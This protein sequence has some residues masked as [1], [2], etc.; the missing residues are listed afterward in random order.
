VVNLRRMR[1]D[2]ITEHFGALAVLRDAGLIQHLGLSD[3]TTAHLA[4]ALAIAPV[5][6]VQ[7]R[8]SL[9]VREHEG[10]L[11]A[12][13]EQGI[14]FVPF[15]AIAGERR[16][17]GGSGADTDQL[18]EVARWH[19]ATPAQVRLAWTLQQGPNVLAIPG[20]GNPG[21]LTENVAADALR[22]TEQDLAV[23]DSSA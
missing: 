4:E 13:R 20:T 12:C 9:K 10:V 22:L 18:L 21:H 6:C 1:Q 5:V 23:L 3:V 8:F 14:A 16:A 17:S 15:F 2:S 11:R 19:G 7:N